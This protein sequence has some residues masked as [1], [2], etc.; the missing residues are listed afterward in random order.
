M[1]ELVDNQWW[2]VELGEVDG[3]EELR[4]E[5]VENGWLWSEVRKTGG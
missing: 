1:V 4:V 3:V 2:W 5:V